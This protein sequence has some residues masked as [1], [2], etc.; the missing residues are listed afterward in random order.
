MLDVLE[1]W[2]GEV[3]SGFKLDAVNQLFETQGFSDEKY[4]AGSVDK[5]KHENLVHTHTKNRV[6][7]E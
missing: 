1:Y 3:V 5:S 6:S 7:D 2:V 4:V